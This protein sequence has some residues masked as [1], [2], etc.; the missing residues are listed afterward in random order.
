MDFSIA[1][2]LN[3]LLPSLDHYPVAF[4]RASVL[5]GEECHI[6]PAVGCSRRSCYDTS[7]YGIFHLCSVQL[8]AAFQTRATMHRSVGKRVGPHPACQISEVRH[9]DPES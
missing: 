3:G 1:L 9:G 8:W 7:L 5:H 6:L 4:L 2:R